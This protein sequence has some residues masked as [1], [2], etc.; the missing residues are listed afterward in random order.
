MKELVIAE[1]KGLSN[2]YVY[3]L[4]EDDAVAAYSLEEAKE[5]Y[6]ELTGLSDDELYSDDDVEVIDM[7]K[8]VWNDECLT[9]K[10]TVR[11]IVNTYWDGEPFIAVTSYF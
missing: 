1:Q 9:T 7:S 2:V 5:W 11:E 8:E 4:C 6:K 3:Q 10:T